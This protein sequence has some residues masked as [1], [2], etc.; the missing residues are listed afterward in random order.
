MA[1]AKP[2]VMIDHWAAELAAA[3][4][5]SWAYTGDA[6]PRTTNTDINDSTN[7]LVLTENASISN[8]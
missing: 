2:A 7:R 1:S 5:A 6:R 8:P 4:A 3:P